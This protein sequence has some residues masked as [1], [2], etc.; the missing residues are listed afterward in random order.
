[1]TNLT[2][3]QNLIDAYKSAQNHVEGLPPFIIE[4][5]VHSKELMQLYKAT[6]CL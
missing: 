3:S 5:G 1:M 2:I 6:K 4:V